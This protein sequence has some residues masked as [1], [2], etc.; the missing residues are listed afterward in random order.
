MAD[1]IGF[2]YLAV[3]DT[4]P[5]L[6]KIGLT[7]GD[8][9]ERMKELSAD[10]GVPAPFACSYFC[11]VKN[12]AVVEKQLHK[13]FGF[14]RESGNREFFR[15]DWRAVQAAIEMMS[16]ADGA[17]LDDGQTAKSGRRVGKFTLTKWVKTGNADNVRQV[18]AIG[19]K[20]D[21]A[22]GNK[23]T[24]LMWA[25]EL[26]Y[27]DIANIL[28]N[29][30]ADPNKTDKKGRTALMLAAKRGHVDIAKALLE[31][32]AYANTTDKEGQTALDKA[33]DNI[34]VVKALLEGGADA[35]IGRGG[36]TVLLN[37][38]AIDGNNEIVKTLLDG[39]VNP[40]A[41]DKDG[42]TAL[43]MAAYNGHSEIAKILLA[44]GANP[45]AA[46]KYGE[47]ALMIAA[48]NNPQNS[49]HRWGGDFDS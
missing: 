21:Q 38:A 32:G 40:N 46:R 47:T 17:R 37:K 27:A 31:F 36:M 24:A 14:C 10:T 33:D 25:A 8:V 41:A 23:Q 48:H 44:A 45:N 5:G 13:Q 49:S 16:K 15:I 30:D 43:M 4:M 35:T 19:G 28:L 1:D 34:E 7:K 22:D 2:I 3:N 39:G 20:P 6:V 18:L 42:K 9:R 12:P 26:G 29:D 11:K